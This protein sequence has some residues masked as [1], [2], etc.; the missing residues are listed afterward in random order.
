MEKSIK[1]DSDLLDKAKIFSDYK[2]EKHVTEEALKHFI[3]LKNI[4]NRE[5]K[6]NATGNKSANSDILNDYLELKKY[7]RKYIK[8]VDKDVNLIKMADEVNDDIF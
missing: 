6:L 8:K 4:F 1:I 2:T 7:N 3:L 5:R